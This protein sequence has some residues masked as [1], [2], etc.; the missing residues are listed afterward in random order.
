VKRSLTALLAVMLVFGCA[1]KIAGPRMPPLPARAPRG[2]DDLAALSAGS[3]EATLESFEAAAIRTATAWV[4]R[5][6]AARKA[7]C[8]GA[9][10]RASDCLNMARFDY[11]DDCIDPLDAGGFGPNDAT[12]RVRPGP[13][14]LGGGAR[15]A[16]PP[17]R[18]FAE[19]HSESNVQ[20]AGVDEPDVVKNDA[21]YVYVAE[22]GYF[23]VVQAWPPEATR[24]IAKVFVEGQVYGMLLAG[25]QLVV[26]SVPGGSAGGTDITVFALGDRANVRPVRRLRASGSYVGARRIGSAVH[27]VVAQQLR[28][29][30]KIPN[31]TTPSIC[32]ADLDDLYADVRKEMVRGVRTHSFEEMIPTLED[33]SLAGERRTTGK[34][35][36]C[37]VYADLRHAREPAGYETSIVSF[38]LGGGPASMIT[39]LAEPS[40]LYASPTH[41]YVTRPARPHQRGGGALEGINLATTVDRFRL[42][43]ARATYAGSAVVPGASVNQYAMDEHEGRFRIAT[44]ATR[45]AGKSTTLTVIGDHAGT[46]A[47]ESSVDRI[48]PGEDIR[49]VRF[50]G[51]RAYVV[52][53]RVVD[54]LFVFDLAG[55]RARRLG[56]LTIAGFSTYLHPIG[57][58]HLLTIGLDAH[59]GPGGATHTGG[60]R[61]QIVDVADPS[62]PTLRHKEILSE[63]GSA[64][65]YDPLAFLYLGAPRNLLVLPVGATAHE[66]GGFVVYDA[67]VTSGFR[68]L[69]KPT[70]ADRSVVRTLVMED[71]ILAVSRDTLETWRLTDLGASVARVRLFF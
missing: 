66:L 33:A 44:M 46:L 39:T 30:D 25:E 27:V 26:L 3:C 57:D 61:L 49:G 65:L 16:S 37:N 43:G 38:D 45:D 71:Y 31:V 52:T 34:M 2:P 12:I 54:P 6:H 11:G 70:P 41:L 56:E 62:K 42:D 15:A 10:L 21:K 29:E 50:V 64:A 20:V 48:A 36:A 14:G 22:D 63:Q 1:P 17:M 4:E 68:L 18:D 5:Q 67:S 24:V 35:L 53:F 23:L 19:Q 7:E 13:V 60:V 28:W 58:S 59:E 51:D 40:H 9:P 69:G 55:G 47:I 32:R 8:G